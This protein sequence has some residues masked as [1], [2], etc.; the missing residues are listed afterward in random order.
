MRWL[1]FLLFFI[2][3]AAPTLGLDLSL[4]PGLS[5][6]NA[7]LYLVFLGTAIDTAIRRNRSFE[8]GSVVIPYALCFAYA[9]YTWLVIVLVIDYPGYS[10]LSSLV[11]L[12]G[13]P[14][15]TSWCSLSSSM[16]SSRYGMLPG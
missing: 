12:K 1:L 9:I 3:L 2:L 15:I 7:F 4:A 8:A 6:K 10:R 13:S 14:S 5:V 11:I 16:P